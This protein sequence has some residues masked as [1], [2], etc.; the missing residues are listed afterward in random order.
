MLNFYR[1]VSKRLNFMMADKLEFSYL[2]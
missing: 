1:P 2:I